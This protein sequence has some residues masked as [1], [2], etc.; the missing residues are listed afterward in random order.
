[1]K[2]QSFLNGGRQVQVARIQSFVEERDMN[3]RFAS[4]ARVCLAI[5]MVVP[6][7]SAQ[8]H[9]VVILKARK[10]G[11]S[12][13]LPVEIN[14]KPF[15]F[16]VDS[17]AYQGVV[18]PLV[19]RQAGLKVI[20]EGS[21][22]GTGQGDVPVKH[23]APLTLRVGSL[24]IA[25]PAPLL[26]DLSGTGNPQWMHGLIGAELFENYV[27]EMDF[28]RSQFRVFRPDE[29]TPLAK[30]A[31]VPLI[32]ENHRFFIDATLEPSEK[33]TVTHRLRVDTGS[34]DSVADDVVKEGTNVR[35]TTL[36][37]GL[38]ANY[39]GY[40]GVFKLVRLG[41]F[42]FRD[43]WGPAVPHPGIG[44][45]MFRRFVVTF[46]VPHRKLYLQPK[47][48]FEEAFPSPPAQ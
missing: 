19:A 43:V 30:A 39:K 18:D 13:Y 31:S 42:T 3:R 29:F 5:A 41:P 36:G 22:Q 25:V 38:G 46:D 4:A 14:G 33:K 34:E 2:I 26:I 27:V 6:M 1:M 11:K 28:D 23:L 16:A 7:A 24:N 40:S 10:V 47:Q 15:W 45:E 21:V 12:L 32:V 9:P 37:N 17:G 8:A 35:E 20:G 44:M 48:H